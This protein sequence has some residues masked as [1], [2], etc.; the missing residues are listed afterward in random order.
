MAGATPRFW[1]YL[2]IFTLVLAGMA[3]GQSPGPSLDQAAAKLRAAQ[4]AADR[5]SAL[6]Q[7]IRGF[8][9]ALIQA[10]AQQR[11]L[12]AEA[13]AAE[14]ALEQESAE[15]GRIISVLMQNGPDTGPASTSHPQGALAA[16]RAEM[17]AGTL[18]QQLAQ[19]ATPIAADLEELRT[20]RDQLAEFEAAIARA[21]SDAHTARQT[22]LAGSSAP[23]TEIAVSSNSLAAQLRDLPSTRRAAPPKQLPLPVLSDRLETSPTRLTLS[24]APAAIVTAPSP[25]SVVFAGRVTNQGVTLVLDLGGARYLMLSGLASSL[26][27]TG[28]SVTKDTALGFLPSLSED[29]NPLNPQ[30][31]TGSAGQAA[32]YIEAREAERAV[33]PAAWFRLDE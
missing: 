26:V 16:A 15:L 33:D 13:R 4:T 2:G 25:A 12:E 28:Q 24:A 17:L 22:L 32:L 20:R 30:K 31:D 23:M 29:T 19:L 8:E 10:R 7:A 21:L 11:D 6:T 3:W 9:A 14:A 5:Q 1:A 18:S 27:Q